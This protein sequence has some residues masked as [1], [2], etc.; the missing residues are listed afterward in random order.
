MICTSCGAE[1][2]D[3]VLFCEKCKAD[4][5]MPAGAAGDTPPPAEEPIP[6]EPIELEPVALEPVE[7]APQPA[8]FEPA[9][10]APEPAPPPLPAPAAATN[11][12]L[13]VVRGQRL[14]VSYP[15]YPGKNFIGRNDDKPVDIDLTDQEA[16]DRIWA[17][18][19]HAVVT[20][21]DGKLAI[22]DLNS[23]N[24]T[25]VNRARVHPGQVRELN[26]DDVV[27]IG[28]VHFRVQLG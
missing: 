27:Q 1:N 8:G 6:L 2:E 11:P 3:G 14:D 15:L 12:T 19:Q 28:T 21:D 24:G 17:S 22:E 20:L 4:L 7:P 5:E 13:V 26:N 18:R 16:E 25:F 23:L 10:T 9:G